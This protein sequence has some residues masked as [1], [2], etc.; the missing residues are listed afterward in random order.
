MRS[1][2]ILKASWLCWLCLVLSLALPASARDSRD[3]V[4]AY[5]LSNVSEHGATVHLTMSLRISNC[6]EQDLHNGA[7]ALLDGQ[8]HPNLIGGFAPIQL[9]RVHQ[10]I[11]LHQNFD[12][13]K[14]EYDRWQ[15]GARP[16]L[17]FLSK[18][19]NGSVR[20]Q[21]ISLDNREAWSDPP[22]KPKQ[23]TQK[24]N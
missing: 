24:G 17:A 3:F 13:P 12:V 20:M 22:G 5:R 11:T 18:E 15:A 7:L 14:Q 2:S 9:L 1:G 16:N 4:G 10:A 21:S 6:G 19:V 8:P 23:P